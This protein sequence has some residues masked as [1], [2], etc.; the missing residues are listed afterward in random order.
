MFL[1]NKFKKNT[2]REIKRDINRIF[3]HPKK[4]KILGVTIGEEEASIG[5]RPPVFMLALMFGVR[6]NR[7][8]FDLIKN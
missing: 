1:E 7:S 8:F 3:L 4:R 6:D 5:S 2:L